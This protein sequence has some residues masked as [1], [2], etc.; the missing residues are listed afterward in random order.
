M[1]N[2]KTNLTIQRLEEFTLCG[3]CQKEI[4]SIEDGNIILSIICNEVEAS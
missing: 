4:K 3:K 1:N 2:E